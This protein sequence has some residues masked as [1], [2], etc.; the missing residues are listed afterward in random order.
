MSN[1]QI[2]NRVYDLEERTAVF[3]ENIIVLCR[4]LPKDDIT[5][6][7]IPQLVGAGTAVGSNYCEADCA[8]SN[9]DFIHKIAIANK[10]AKESKHFLRM[11]AKACP[12]FS[13]EARLLW[14]EGHEL[15]S[16]F[17]T[18]IKKAKATEERKKYDS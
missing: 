5:K 1:K 15:N 18:I 10:E 3:G 14:K 6:R 2:Q 17:T 7:I 8:E 12:E 9:K 4:K 16:I 13:D 11:V